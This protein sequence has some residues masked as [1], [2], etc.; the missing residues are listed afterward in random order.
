[1]MEAYVKGVSTR[2][3]DALVVALGG[4]TRGSPNPRCRASARSSTRPWRPSAAAAWTTRSSPTSF[5]T[6]PP[7]EGRGH[8]PQRS[9]RRAPRRR[10]SRRRPRRIPSHRPPLP[11]RTLHDPTTPTPRYDHN[12]RTNK[13]LPTS[14]RPRRWRSR[15]LYGRCRP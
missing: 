14:T 9:R 5:W 11:L 12:R 10:H 3:V 2:S 8:L 13:W 7:L 6:P 4:R 1:M 15:N